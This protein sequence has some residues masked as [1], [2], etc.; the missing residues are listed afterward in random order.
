MQIAAFI[1]RCA[2]LTADDVRRLVG[3]WV[4]ARGTAWVATRD[5]TRGLLLRDLIGQ[6]PGWDQAAYDLLTGPWR[7]TI[8]P[9]HPD[10]AEMK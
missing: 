7:R 2:T 3:A 9:I 5:A 8:G 10:D 6:R 1:E 4:G